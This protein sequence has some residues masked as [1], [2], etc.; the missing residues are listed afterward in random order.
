MRCAAGA[1]RTALV[2]D[3]SWV[4]QLERHVRESDVTICL[5]RSRNCDAPPNSIRAIQN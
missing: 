4:A 3:L 5:P 2:S 1:G